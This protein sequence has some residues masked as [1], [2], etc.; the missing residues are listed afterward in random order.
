MTTKIQLIDRAYSKLKISGITVNPTADDVSLAIAELETMADEWQN[1]RN[2][3]LFYN[4]EDMPDPAT[5]SGIPRRYENG[6]QTN[7][8]MRLAPEFGKQVPQELFM[9]ASQSLDAISGQAMREII[10]PPLYP[11]RQPVGEAN[12]LRF[13]RWR[14]YYDVA[15]GS[16]ENCDTQIMVEHDTADYTVNYRETLNDGATIA[17]YTIEV[18]D[19]LRLIDTVKTDTE[20]TISVEARKCGAQRAQITT[21]STD[22][23]KDNRTVYFTVVESKQIKGVQRAVPTA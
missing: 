6:V 23:L 5:E 3:C 20:I 11:R 4:F 12:S 15:K 1:T 8:A 14:R 22:G 16:P 9:Q 21:T 7:L 17:S 13:N 18:S 19:G 2:I 10:S